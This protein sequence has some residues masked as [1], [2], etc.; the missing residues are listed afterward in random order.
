MR[1]AFLIATILCIATNCT[2]QQNKFQGLWANTRYQRITGYIDKIGIS[3]SPRFIK[4]DSGGRCKIMND[5]EHFVDLG[6]PVTRKNEGVE[7]ELTYK[8]RL[9]YVITTNDSTDQFMSLEI[10]SSGFYVLLTRVQE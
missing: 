3:K 9:T 10:S 5:A 4:I 8:G 1:Y 2:G 7:E 6:L